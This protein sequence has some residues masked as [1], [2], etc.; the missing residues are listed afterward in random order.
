VLRFE[1]YLDQLAYWP[2]A[3]RH[4]L[5][6]FD[7]E[8]IVVYQ[9]YRSSIARYALEHAGLGG[10]FSYERMSWIKTNFLWMM[11]RSGW[12]TKPGQETILAIRLKRPFFDSLLSQAVEST[13][14]AS[15]FATPQ[16][17]KHALARSSVRMQWDPDHGPT[18]ASQV[19]RALQIGLR[20]RVLKEYGRHQILEIIDLSSFVTAQRGN[21]SSESRTRLVTPLERVYIPDAPAI[22]SR[23]MLD[24]YP[25]PN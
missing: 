11:Y 7:A 12:G 6:Q 20:G 13:Y 4:I 18:G 15:Q 8:S 22:K 24:D 23:L 1:P 19:R 17:W 25:M 21:I 3:G 2:R 5:A 9:A 14:N 10:E 16:D